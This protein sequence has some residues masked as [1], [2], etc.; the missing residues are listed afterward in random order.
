MKDK[1][2]DYVLKHSK[3]RDQ[4][5]KYDFMSPLLEIIERPAHTGGKVIIYALFSLLVFVIVW[6]CLSKVDVVVTGSGSVKPIGDINTIQSYSSGTIKAI[7]IS[8]G[9]YVKKDDLLMELATDGVT[10]DVN[11]INYQVS[12]LNLQL[13]LYNKIQSGIDITNTSEK[14]YDEKMQSLALTVIE[15]EKNYKNKLQVLEL[16][17]KDKELN[18]QLAV[19]K[20]E[21][22]ASIPEYQSE[23]HNQDIMIQQYKISVEEAEKNI[24]NAKTEHDTYIAKS[25]SEIKNK[26]TELNSQLEKA[27]INQNYQKI[28]S[29]VNG[30]INSIAVNTIGGVVSPTQKLF[31]IV[32]SEAPVEMVC[33]VKNKDIAD[34]NVGDKVEIKLEAYPY[35][36]YGTVPGKVTYI[37]P[38]S[39]VDKKSG[40]VYLIK[41]KINNKNKKI[42]IK[43]GLSGSIEIKVGKRSVMSYFLDPIVEGLESSL[44][45]K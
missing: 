33:Y 27:N 12:A 39:F 42:D 32:P 2:V 29:P 26:L 21:K 31:T 11:Q 43:T 40:S 15:S 20:K 30:Y 25:I 24:Q 5:L 7:H 28:T 36:K 18:Y 13:D 10:V 4:E 3:K 8:E 17:K 37:S 44:K 45:E 23:L 19:N 6:A 1:M 38:S 22:Y 34:I 14:K 41:V 35:S 16:Q 9:Q